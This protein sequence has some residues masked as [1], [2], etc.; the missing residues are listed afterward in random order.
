MDGKSP[1]IGV[2]L[3]GG[4][5]NLTEE[6]MI[7][8]NSIRK[9]FLGLL[10]VV[11]T[12]SGQ[13]YSQTSARVF[14]VPPNDAIHMASGGTSWCIQMEPVNGSFQLTD[15]NLC[16]VTLSSPGNGSVNS[17]NYNCTKPTL[18]ED[19]DGNG[20]Q[21]IRFCFTKTAM[22]PLFDHLHGNS[23]KTVQ[24]LLSGL[25]NNGSNVGGSV[26]VTLYLH[27]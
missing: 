7:H 5:T 26:L 10:V 15:I 14:V 23:P 2:G 1:G 18:I 8:R 3:A 20:V 6:T 19:A 21:D 16:S 13:A 17:I 22:A 11:L 27:Q 12:W 25:L 4:S 9:A 24:M